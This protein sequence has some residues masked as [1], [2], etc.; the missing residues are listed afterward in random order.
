MVFQFQC[1]QGHLLEAEPSQ[2]GQHCQCPVCG[3]EFLIPAP[4]E[5]TAFATPVQ[6]APAAPGPPS[7]SEVPPLEAGVA[8]GALS[9]LAGPRLLHIPCPSG[10]ELEVPPDMIGQDV[11]CPHCQVQFRLREQDS[12][13]YKRRKQEEL[14]LKDYKAGKTWFMWAVIFAILVVLGLIIMI[15]VGSSL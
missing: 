8:P 4:I 2:A 1:P 9:E 12:V 3:Q 15:A 7:V 10:H 14:E 5:Q 6:E 13:E 11:L